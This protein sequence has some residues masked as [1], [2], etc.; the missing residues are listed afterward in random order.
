MLAWERL[1][2]LARNPIP[3]ASSD[4]SLSASFPPARVAATHD[5]SALTR[6]PI[7]GLDL[8]PR[9]PIRPTCSRCHFR[10]YIRPALFSS[11]LCRPRCRVAFNN[12][13]YAATNLRSCEGETKR[14]RWRERETEGKREGRLNVNAVNLLSDAKV[15][16]LQ[17]ECAVMSTGEQCSDIRRELRRAMC[18]RLEKNSWKEFYERP[19][20]QLCQKWQF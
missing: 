5:S 13:P 10:I 3:P 2:V 17:I 20:W 15:K 18:I 6:G 4:N 7:L 8:Y 12:F 14:D 11:L 16:W 19:N 9:L 1:H